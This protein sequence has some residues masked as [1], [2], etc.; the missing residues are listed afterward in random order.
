METI[1]L[2]DKLNREQEEEFI[3]KLSEQLEVNYVTG[4]DLE[5]FREAVRPVY[6]YFIDQGDFTADEIERARKAARGGG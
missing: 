6:E 3:D 2:S 1:A 5:P 4:A